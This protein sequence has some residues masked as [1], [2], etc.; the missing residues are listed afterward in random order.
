MCSKTQSKEQRTKSKKVDR[1][2]SFFAFLIPFAA[3]NRSRVF[4]LFTRGT[5]VLIH[6]SR[7]TSFSIL[8]GS[9]FIESS[10]TKNE[11]QNLSF[12]LLIYSGLH[13][14]RLCVLC[15]RTPRMLEIMVTMNRTVQSCHLFVTIKR[16]ISEFFPCRLNARELHRAMRRIF[17]NNEKSH[18]AIL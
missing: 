8:I 14:V 6:I 13:L 2:F 15:L 17:G 16:S 5:K 10:V 4:S 11:R 9:R 12:A 18:N 7:Y 1:L 3:Q